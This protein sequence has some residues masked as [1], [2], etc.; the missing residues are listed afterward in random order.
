MG[1]VRHHSIIV[2]GRPE[3]V[4][5]VRRKVVAVLDAASEPLVLSHAD[6]LVSEVVAS[7][8][9]DKASFFV[10]ADGSQ[11]GFST[12]DRMDRARAEIVAW[13]DSLDAPPVDWVEVQYGDDGGVQQV[14]NASN[15]DRGA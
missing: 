9:N 3:R 2:T 10:A 1:Y 14:D 15:W 6:S 11:E 12:S 13:L 5:L 4:E 7:I 8:T